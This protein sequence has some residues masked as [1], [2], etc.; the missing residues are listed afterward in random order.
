[1]AN[2]AAIGISSQPN[3]HVGNLLFNARRRPFSD[4]VTLTQTDRDTLTSEWQVQVGARFAGHCP[5]RG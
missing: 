4:G 2:V 3:Q 1:M 5:I